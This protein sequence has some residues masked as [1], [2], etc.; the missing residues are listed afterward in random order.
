[1][2]G[3]SAAG[4]ARAGTRWAI[5]TVL[6]P[7]S[8]R[9]YSGPPDEI[10]SELAHDEAVQAADTLLLTVPNQLGVEYNAHLLETIVREIAPALGWR[11]APVSPV[12]P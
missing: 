7:G 5:L 4:H 1:M 11:P 12:P 9:S 2:T 8:G 10:A 3:Y 6:S